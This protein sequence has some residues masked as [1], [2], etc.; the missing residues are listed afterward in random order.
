MI[1]S[2]AVQATREA[3]SV[4]SNPTMT[5]QEVSSASGGPGPFALAAIQR[6][7]LAF[8]GIIGGKPKMVPHGPVCIIE[9]T[10]YCQITE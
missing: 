7:D 2:K 1:S 10:A 5:W 6:T 4:G 8:G 9:A 3:V